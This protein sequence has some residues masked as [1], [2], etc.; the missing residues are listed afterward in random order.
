GHVRE[1]LS[2]VNDYGRMLASV[3][4]NGCAVNNVNAN[5]L[6]LSPELIPQI[7]RVADAFRPWGVKVALAIDF[8]SPQTLGKL[9]TYDP[10][11]P[12]VIAWWKARADD[13]YKTIPDFGGFVLKADS[14]GRVGPS[15]YGRTHADAANVVA[16]APAP[17][18]R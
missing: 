12:T 13:L 1:D 11:D 15:A 14:E 18:G 10:L 5:T 17:H 3:G 8:G 2:R 7:A 16:R 6:F 4:I 9:P